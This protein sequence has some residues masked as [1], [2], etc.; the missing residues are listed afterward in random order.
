MVPPRGR[1]GALKRGYTSGHQGWALESRGAEQ[2]EPG[3]DPIGAQVNAPRQAASFTQEE[4]APELGDTRRMIAYDEGATEY[5]PGALLPKIAQV[6]RIGANGLLDGPNQ[7]DGEARPEPLAVAAATSG[8]PGADRGAPGAASA[9][10]LHRARA[11][12]AHGKH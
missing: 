9:R 7:N 11:V 1:P 4:L 2:G 12:E 8:E 10:C 5:P 3:A 6:P